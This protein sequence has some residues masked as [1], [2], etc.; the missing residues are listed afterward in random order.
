MYLLSWSRLCYGITIYII[1]SLMQW[2]SDVT[3]LRD[4]WNYCIC[5]IIKRGSYNSKSI[6]DPNINIIIFLVFVC[7]SLYT[8]IPPSYSYPLIGNASILPRNQLLAVTNLFNWAT[9]IGVLAFC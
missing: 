2:L 6:Y 8:I 7:W 5:Y 3:C 4:K 1:R 9:M